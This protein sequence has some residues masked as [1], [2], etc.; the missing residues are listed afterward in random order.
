MSAGRH[1]PT[2]RA[3]RPVMRTVLLASAAVAG[4]GGLVVL[5]TGMADAQD[6]PN[7]S[8]TL[9]FGSSLSIDDNKGLDPVSAG[10]TTNFD[11]RIGLSYL[12]ETATSALGLNVSSVL[13][14]SQTPGGGSD[15][16]FDDPAVSINYSR[17]GANS[18]LAFSATH[19]KADVSF[20]DPLSLIED[21]ESPVD[22]GDLS[23]SDTGTRTD[24]SLGL[25]LETGVSGPL[26]L[27]FGL[28]QRT[29]DF[30][31]TTDPD[32]FDTTTTSMTLGATLRM[33]ERTSTSLTLARTD[34]DAEDAVQ[35]ARTTDRVTLGLEHAI[36]P[37]LRLSASLGQSRITVDET[38][39][40]VTTRRTNDG[41]SASLGLTRDLANGT[42]GLNLGQ[43]VSINGT[44]TNLTV[45]R[46]MDLPTGALDL[47][48]GASRASG[49]S[50]TWIGSLGYNHELPRGGIRASLNRQA[51]TN[52]ADED[53]T[54]T[55]A[56]LG[57]A[58]EMTDTT[59]IDLS[60]DYLDVDSSTVGDDRTRTR[61]RLAYTWDLPQDWRLAGGY[62]RTESQNETAGRA[63]SNVLFLSLERALTFAP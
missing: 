52:S 13:R 11:N 41:L 29:R 31:G 6:G 61:L 12:T 43:E 18:T 62:T 10:T 9:T 20:F 2:L 44:R 35:T 56:Q 30:S 27:T 32:H 3:A 33:G 28:S 19:R 5:G 48:F 22:P 24:R 55:R 1:R 36:S 15:T 8:L 38:V 39:G 21:P 4:M 50:A 14:F 54:T 26:G 45:S 53:V 42:L 60:L 34:F 37:D 63:H 25:N 47:T 16:S 7:P 40:L 59:G 17:E 49:G 57:W 58:H 51:G 23:T 46:A